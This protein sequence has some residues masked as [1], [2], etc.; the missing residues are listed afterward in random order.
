MALLQTVG[1]SGEDLLDQPGGQVEPAEMVGTFTMLER[2]AE[3]SPLPRCR[4]L[5]VVAVL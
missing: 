2:K 1:R 4:K 3:D 5:L